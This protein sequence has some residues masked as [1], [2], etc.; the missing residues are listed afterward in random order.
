ME[1]CLHP[2]H[3]IQAAGRIHRLGQNEDVLVTRFCFKRSFEQGIV[4]LHEQI[5]EGRVEISDQHVPG[6]VVNRLIEAQ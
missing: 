6:I 2:A 3:E 4:Q 1:P 5:A